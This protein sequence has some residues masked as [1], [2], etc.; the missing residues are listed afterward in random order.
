MYP[1]HTSPTAQLHSIMT[2]LAVAACNDKC[3]VGKLDVKG[4]FIQTEMTGVSV[5]IKCAGRLK[6]VI[7]RTYPELTKYVGKD[8]VLYCKLLK[9]LYGCVQASK[10]WY[11]KLSKFLEIEGYEKCEVDQCIFRRLEGEMVYLLAVYV[12]DVLIIAPEQEIKRLEE[13]FIREFKW[14]TLE[15]GNVHSYLGMQLEF[16]RGCVKIDMRSYLDGVLKGV[17]GLK[18]YQGPAGS[19][20]F[21]VA[22][23]VVK[24]GVNDAQRFHTVVAKL[25]YLSRRAWPDIIAT[26]SFL[27][28]RVKEPTVQDR[29][30]LFHL[31]GYLQRT[32]ERVLTLRPRGIFKL[33]A[34]IDASFA[35]HPDGKSHTGIVIL[36]G[37]VRVFFA[38]RKQKCVSKSPTEA[39]LVALSDNVGFVELFHEFVSFVLNCKIGTPT[40]YQ[41]NTSVISLVTIGGGV[42]RT[43]H[44]RTRMYLVM[45]ALKEGKISVKYIHTSEMFADGLTKVLDGADFDSFANRALN[46]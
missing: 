16:T 29:E 6:H 36:L 37:G 2:C 4:A 31:L 1:D 15:M 40:V 19:G 32:K 27:C 33:E 41:D 10:L 5:Y 38:S 44:L 18:L 14:V 26:V 13:S 11:L 34:Y 45:E 17:S 24:L 22:L 30:K 43:K 8:G 3:S 9:A 28:T 35:L 21:N 23:D 25:L 46:G 7:I 42:M 20:L 12:D 39:E